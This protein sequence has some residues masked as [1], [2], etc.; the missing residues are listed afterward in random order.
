[1][2][3]LRSRI[4]RVSLALACAM[5][6]PAAGA[7]PAFAASP[8]V[9]ELDASARAS[10]NRLDIATQIGDRV[11]ASMLPAQVSQISANEFGGHL[12]LG[13]RMWGV[14]F[15]KPI[16]QREFVD[17]VA[18]LIRTAFAIAPSAEEV[19]VWTSVPID[20]TRDIIVSGDLARPTSRV[21]FTLSVPHAASDAATI[22]R[23]AA[24]DAAFWDREWVRSA[25]LK[26]TS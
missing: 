1:M 24:G 26:A 2:P 20:V 6:A 15:H 3:I 4:N 10:G 16:T 25:F 5:I 8:S 14:K 19:D 7:S 13:I 18:W 9:A 22:T 17:Q 12:V 23:L 21:V 11:F